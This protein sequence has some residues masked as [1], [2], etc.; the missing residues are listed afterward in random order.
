MA[1]YF[2]LVW[3]SNNNRFYQVISEALNKGGWDGNIYGRFITAKYL[4]IY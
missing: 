3:K 2:C 4:R 1:Y